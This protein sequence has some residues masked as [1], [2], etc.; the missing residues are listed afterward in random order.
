MKKPI[1]TFIICVL[2]LTLWAQNSPGERMRILK[3]D[4]TEIF[5]VILKDD[6]KNIFMESENLGKIFIPKRELK[7]ISKITEKEEEAIEVPGTWTEENPFSTRHAFT[8]NAFP[9]KKGENYGMLNFHGPEVHFA[10]TDRFNVGMM[11][12]WLAS[13][14]AL[15]AKYSFK[16][17]EERVHFSLGTLMMSSGFIQGFR[18]FGNLSFANMTLGNRNANLTLSAGYLYYRSGRRFIQDGTTG[19]DYYYSWRGGNQGMF[20]FIGTLYGPGDLPM[21]KAYPLGGPIV[22]VGGIYRVGKKATF[23]FDS[24][25]GS[26][27]GKREHVENTQIFDPVSGNYLYQH[28]VSYLPYNATFFFL[29]PGMRFQSTEN[30]AWQL[31]IAETSVIRS[32]QANAT[33]FPFP[34]ITLFKKF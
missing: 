13:P 4:G 21:Q 14:L 30:F 6:G 7:S 27:Q 10:L 24:M 26:L 18:G 17:K 15:A 5:G 32:D 20:N 12:S 34:M 2:G 25:F 1:I 8:T 22:S 3:Y 31:T 9:I 19:T 16:T 29:A 23:I 11:T 28:T 33:N